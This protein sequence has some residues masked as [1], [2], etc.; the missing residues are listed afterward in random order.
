MGFWRNVGYIIAVIIIAAGVTCFIAAIAASPKIE[1]QSTEI[2][3]IAALAGV[4]SLALIGFGGM[5]SG[6]L[7]IW[8]LKKS[9]QFESMEK[10]LR[11]IANSIS[12][13]ESFQKERL[14]DLENQEKSPKDCR[15]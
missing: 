5:I 2:G 15:F 4:S 1:T 9:G 10:S 8:A 11:K 13:I 14:N 6:I 3:N 12:V 7:L